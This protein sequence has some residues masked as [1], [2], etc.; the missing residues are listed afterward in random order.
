MAV[1]WDFF[2]GRLF[3]LLS[4]VLQALPG[5]FQFLHVLS[6][7]F[8]IWKRLYVSIFLNLR[9]LTCKEEL[10]PVTNMF[11]AAPLLAIK[12]QYNPFPLFFSADKS[13]AHP[14]AA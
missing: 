1:N 14:A 8:I 7:S 5:C 12:F 13:A 4:M 6:I 9:W 10:H 11:L 2:S 3:S